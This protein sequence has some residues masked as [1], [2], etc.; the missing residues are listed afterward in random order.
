MGILSGKH[1]FFLCIHLKDSVQSMHHDEKRF[2]E[3][4]VANLL[5]HVFLLLL[6]SLDFCGCRPTCS[7]DARGL[8]CRILDFI[9][10]EISGFLSW[11]DWKQAR[12]SKYRF[13][14]YTKHVLSCWW[15]RSC[16]STAKFKDDSIA[17][18]PVQDTWRPYI[19]YTKGCELW[20]L[21]CVL[22]VMVKEQWSRPTSSQ[23]WKCSAHV[24][25]FV[26][27]LGRWRV[28]FEIYLKSIYLKSICWVSD[29]CS[30]Y[31][32]IYKDD[33]DDC[34]DCHSV[35]DRNWGRPPHARSR[36]QTSLNRVQTICK[37]GRTPVGSK[38]GSICLSDFKIFKC[39]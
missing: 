2:R 35:G 6:R 22:F 23:G 27:L 16:Y 9:F 1:V 28:Q 4:N 13:T 33:C 17:L 7:V 39:K 18:S 26:R 34:D 36:S 29:V 12:P 21:D 3:T 31:L 14:V 5:L 10:A 11:W 37:S 19:A 32:E 24:Q 15:K 30:R 38:T 20:T 25:V 8:M